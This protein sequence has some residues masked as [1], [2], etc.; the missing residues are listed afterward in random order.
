MDENTLYILI[1]AGGAICVV[2][3]IVGG[4]LTLNF[5]SI[6]NLSKS[7]QIL[8][9]IFGAALISVSLVKLNPGESDSNTTAT[10][11]Q[12]SNPSPTSPAEGAPTDKPAPN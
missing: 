5:I 10:S 9:A 3:A 4:G 6:P 1:L 7:R 8:L 12:G 2:A 11:D